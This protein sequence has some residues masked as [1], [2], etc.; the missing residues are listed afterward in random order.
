MSEKHRIAAMGRW[1]NIPERERKLRMKALR[2]AAWNKLT[3][4]QKEAHMKKMRE[5]M[6]KKRAKVHDIISGNE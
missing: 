5:G 3:P 6:A 2:F 1:M 4:E